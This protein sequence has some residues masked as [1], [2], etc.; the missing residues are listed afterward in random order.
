MHRAIPRAPNSLP[1]IENLTRQARQ[2][3][4]R[5]ASIRNK[6][7]PISPQHATTAVSQI[8]ANKLCILCN[9]ICCPTSI[10]RLSSSSSPSF[11]SVRALISS[12]FRPCGFWCLRSPSQTSWTQRDRGLQYIAMK[13]IMLMLPPCYSTPAMK[14]FGVLQLPKNSVKP[15]YRG[16]RALQSH[17]GS[18]PK[19][20]RADTWSFI[21][22]RSRRRY[23]KKT[24]S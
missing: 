7:L 8:S 11:V 17:Y 10:R 2:T 4:H 24:P 16:H 20:N 14:V 6:R 23:P 5:A 9:P 15:P 19:A 21:E 3:V 13:K 22:L 12:S 1:L 18:R